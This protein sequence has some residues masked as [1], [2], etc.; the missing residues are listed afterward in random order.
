MC[1]FISYC[2]IIIINKQRKGDNMGLGENIKKYRKAKK[3]TQSELAELIE[4]SLRMVQKY[5][6]N[7]VTPS[8]EIIGDIAKALDVER[9]DLLIGSPDG[10]TAKEHREEAIEKMLSDFKILLSKVG[11]DLSDYG[12]KYFF[13]SYDDE[14]II[15]KDELIDMHDT[16][17]DY[18]KF[19]VDRSYNKLNDDKH[20]STL[21]EINIVDEP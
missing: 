14:I 21:E 5:E 8:L 15:N 20:K 9:W 7:D 17:M 13:S 11:Y 16:V 1:T 4:K 2:A 18:V 6:A 12:D 3:I 10:K 19:T